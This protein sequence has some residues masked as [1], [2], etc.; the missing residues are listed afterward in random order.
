M[1]GGG[2]VQK[3][4]L[5]VTFLVQCKLPFP[6]ILNTVSF[7]NLL[8]RA[9][10]NNAYRPLPKGIHVKQKSLGATA[11]YAFV[12][13]AQIT[14]AL[15]VQDIDTTDDVEARAMEVLEA[16]GGKLTWHGFTPLPTGHGLGLWS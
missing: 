11:P 16:R 6:E 1:L 9:L 10:S 5:W 8:P 3:F 13:A 2:G 4:G 15:P 7:E 14:T 12:L